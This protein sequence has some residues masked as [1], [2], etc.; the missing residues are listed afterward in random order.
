MIS[1]HKKY[2][3]AKCQQRG[4][5]LAA[6]MPCVVQKRG[7][8]WT[9]DERHP[10]YPRPAEFTGYDQPESSDTAVV[11]AFFSAAGFEAPARNANAVLKD[12]RQA[13]MP[14]F[15]VELLY[16]GQR[17]TLHGGTWTLS[18]SGPLFHKENLWNWASR[19]VPESYSKI[20]FLDADIRFTDRKWLDKTSAVLDSCDLMQ[21]MEFCDWRQGNKRKLTAAAAILKKGDWVH[22]ADHP[23]FALGV[24]REWLERA[25]GLF[26]VTVYGGGD[27]ILWAMAAGKP[28]VCEVCARLKKCECGIAAHRG[29][30][31]W[32]SRAP[33]PR[34]GAHEGCTAIHMPHG[35]TRNRKY[36][37]R[38]IDFPTDLT[39]RRRPDGILEPDPPGAALAY[40][41]SRAEDGGAGSILRGFLGRLGV[42]SGPGCKCLERAAEMDYRGAAWCR[43]NA[44]S[45][46]D[47]LAQEA[48]GRKLPFSTSLAKRLVLKCAQKAEKLE[49]RRMLRAP[50]IPT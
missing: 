8:I 22:G 15:T 21:P 24:R 11:L 41:A 1:G 32:A 3:I 23:G 12:L 30:G 45:I 6:A 50:K 33:R 16:P 47:W 2:F 34:I 37:A 26:D 29:I 31:A 28:P 42:P 43:D 35:L 27:V 49:A 13:R 44:D 39:I 10:A 38:Y 18:A 48:S 36:R 5:P 19:Q 46:V 25:G 17:P 4:V 9:V 20:V 40:F 7:D 14:V